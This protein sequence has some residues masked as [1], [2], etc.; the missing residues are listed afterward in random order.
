[1]T[2]PIEKT[3][4]MTKKLFN[5]WIANLT[6]GKIKQGTEELINADT[7]AMC[8]LGVMEYSAEG[9]TEFGDAGDNLPSMEWLKD[10]N[11]KF[12]TENGD[13]NMA[14]YLTGGEAH[15]LNDNGMSFKQIAQRLKS[16]VKFIPEKK[17]V[18][19]K[20]CKK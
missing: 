6:S 11:V 19:K 5:K 2:K 10:H 7:G 4:H 14:P 20:K 16:R 8:C 1:M 15:E 18:D 17:V 9:T 13:E 12:F 3:I